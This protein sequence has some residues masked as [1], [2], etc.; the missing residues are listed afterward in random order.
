MDLLLVE[1]AERQSSDAF[2][3]NAGGHQQIA[4]DQNGPDTV[5][6]NLLPARA[7]RIFLAFKN[8]REQFGLDQNAR[9]HAEA[10]SPTGKPTYAARFDP[11][12]ISRN[13][14]PKLPFQSFVLDAGWRLARVPCR[15]FHAPE[16]AS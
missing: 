3:A 1:K 15:N 7:L 14:Q 10:D 8:K 13:S 9:N 6:G 12:L 2:G 4:S 16:R 11:R 5:E